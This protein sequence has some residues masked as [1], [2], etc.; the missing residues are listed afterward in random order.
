[1]KNWVKGTNFP[2]HFVNKEDPTVQ[3]VVVGDP[4]DD[5]LEVRVYTLPRDY[6]MLDQLYDE[7]ANNSLMSSSLQREVEGAVRIA[8]E[9]TARMAV[10]IDNTENPPRMLQIP[11]EGGGL[12]LPNPP[13]APLKLSPFSLK[14]LYE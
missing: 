7:E 2:D 13:F 9:H 3:V 5:P 4:L 14:E 11:E 12:A 8:G 1:M 10:L 6:T